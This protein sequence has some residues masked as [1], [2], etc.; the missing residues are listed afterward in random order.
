MRKRDLQKLMLCLTEEE[1]E[2]V[3]MALKTHK[4]GETLALIFKTILDSGQID[5][6]KLSSDH[7][8]STRT[9]ARM[10]TEL[11]NIVIVSVG[12]TPDEPTMEMHIKS[13]LRLTLRMEFDPAIAIIR[14]V[15]AIA[16][17]TE[18]YSTIF[19]LYELSEMIFTPFDLGQPTLDEVVA[20]QHNLWTYE[21]LKVRMKAV[22]NAELSVEVAKD[23]LDEIINH[24]LMDE[25]SS[26][27]SIRAKA[28]YNWLLLR[29]YFHFGE[30]G[31][32]LE[33]QKRLVDMLN[34]NQWLRVDKD[35]F[36]IREN[37][38]LAGL[39]FK[40]ERETEGFKT[41][42]Q[43]GVLAS[44]QAL[45]E[46]SKLNQ[47]YPLKTGLAIRKGDKDGALQSI[48]EVEIHLERFR[49]FLSPLFIYRNQYV[50]AYFYFTTKSFDKAGLILSKYFSKWRTEIPPLFWPMAKVMEIF[51]SY[52]RGEDD[53]TV[54]LVKNIRMSSHYDESPF[55]PIATGLVSRLCNHPKSEHTRILRRFLNKTNSL[56]QDSNAFRIFNFFNLS[57]WIKAELG[58]ST[59][60]SEFKDSSKDVSPSQ[61]SVQDSGAI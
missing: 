3:K 37:E 21:Q 25:E 17:S 16:K 54:R 11:E 13:A 46:V 2:S 15:F 60:L 29:Y 58:N 34:A 53:T 47:L 59:M 14:R 30:M 8:I 56:E 24:P 28:T 10:L 19:V 6:K 51:L 20:L 38:T 42:F 22:L 12:S 50:N 32:G 48:A 33:I 49:G 36:L 39:Y 55:F 27:I 41:I 5:T 31:K 44:E 57:T 40:N 7:K 26:A 1:R 9:F 35:F 45:I 23:R 52:H 4:K 43:T 18:E 61:S